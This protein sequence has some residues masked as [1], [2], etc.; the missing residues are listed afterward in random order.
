[1]SRRGIESH[2]SY[3]AAQNWVV[4]SRPR[5]CENAVVT[6]WW[7][8]IHLSRRCGSR[9][10]EVFRCYVCD[11][12]SC[13]CGAISLKRFHTASTHRRREGGQGYMS[14]SDSPPTTAERPKSG[15]SRRLKDALQCGY[16]RSCPDRWSFHCLTKIAKK[17]LDAAGDAA[18]PFSFARPC[19]LPRIACKR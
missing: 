19:A 4:H 10:A 11:S 15:C 17:L 5:L 13:F 6:T 12:G 8:K 3:G 9:S 14:A 1:M 7:R 18:V 2:T 16:N